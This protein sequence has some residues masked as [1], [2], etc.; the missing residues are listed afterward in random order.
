MLHWGLHVEY[1]LEKAGISSKERREADKVT[2][3]RKRVLEKLIGP[4]ETAKTGF[5]D[6]A[7][8]F[9]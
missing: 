4:E 6:P 5:S 1:E 2:A 7:V 8:L 3:R 9:S